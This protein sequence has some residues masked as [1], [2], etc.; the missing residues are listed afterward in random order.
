M[1]TMYSKLS[2]QTTVTRKSQ[3]DFILMSLGDS[4]ERKSD[5]DLSEESPYDNHLRLIM[6]RMKAP[7][8]CFTVV[9]VTFV[10]IYDEK[11]VSHRVAAL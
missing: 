1:L 9:T 2:L 5:D 7:I 6:K 10:I 11:E 3:S 4:S 8:F